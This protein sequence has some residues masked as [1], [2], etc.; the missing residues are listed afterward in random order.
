MNIKF[1]GT[2]LEHVFFFFNHVSNLNESLNEVVI[3]K[4]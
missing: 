3:K 2:G 4:V 1:F